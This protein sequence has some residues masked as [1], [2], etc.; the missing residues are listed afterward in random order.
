MW[1]DCQAA[2]HRRRDRDFLHVLAN[3]CLASLPPLTFYENDV[4]DSVGE[5]GSTF[6]LEHSALRPLVDVGRVFGMAARRDA[7][8]DRRSNASRRRGR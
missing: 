3:D 6:R 7:W 2:D 1:Q 4:V 8:A 5:H